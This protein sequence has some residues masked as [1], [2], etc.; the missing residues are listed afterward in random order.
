MVRL[1]GFL[2]GGVIAEVRLPPIVTFLA[3]DKR[4]LLRPFA[5]TKRRFK[6]A[7][8]PAPSRLD[9]DVVN[10]IAF[11]SELDV[12]CRGDAWVV[13]ISATGRRLL[14]VVWK[15]GFVL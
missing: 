4:S 9:G 12:A 2:R 8:P 10:A 7:S 14:T 11:G 5:A 6:T 15:E 3:R 1:G 13:V